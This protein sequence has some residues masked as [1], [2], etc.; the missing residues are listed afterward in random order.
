MGPS[1]DVDA[2]HDVKAGTAD[3]LYDCQCSRRQPFSKATTHLSMSSK[4]RQRRMRE[5]SKE[6]AQ[7]E[8]TARWLLYNLPLSASGPDV[9]FCYECEGIIEHEEWCSLSLTSSE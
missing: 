2:R 3:Y 6:A 5:R 1:V 9:R 7:Q 4:R 8:R